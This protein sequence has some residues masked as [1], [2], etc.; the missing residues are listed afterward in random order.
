M[1]RNDAIEHAGRKLITTVT[2]VATTVAVLLAPFSLLVN[3]MPVQRFM[4]H[5]IGTTSGVAARFGE[6]EALQHVR[7]LLWYLAFCTPLTDDGFYS[8]VEHVHLADVRILFQA[9]YWSVGVSLCV[10]IACVI[11]TDRMHRSRLRS[12]VRCGC[13]AALLIVAILG[14]AM[15]LIGFDRFFT[16]FHEAFFTN[17]YWLLPAES[18]LIRLFP[19]SYFLGYFVLALSASV[20]LAAV[21]AVSMHPAKT[22]RL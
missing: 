18:G 12:A 2:A 21:L 4:L 22:G 6:S 3:A 20:L 15:I 10:C 16:L 5:A 1:S 13:I 11:L 19:A 8:T 14:T 17:D 7:N 9:V